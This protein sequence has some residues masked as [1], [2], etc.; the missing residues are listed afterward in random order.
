MDAG[1]KLLIGKGKF[2]F[3]YFVKQ[4]SEMLPRHI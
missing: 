4:V 2:N 1:R 3:S